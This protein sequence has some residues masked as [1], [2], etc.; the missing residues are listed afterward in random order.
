MKLGNKIE[1]TER[2]VLVKT[3]NEPRNTEYHD[4]NIVKFKAFGIYIGYR[5]LNLGYTNYTEDGPQFKRTGTIK[6][7]LVVLN[8]RKNPIYI[9]F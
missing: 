3:Y 5:Y 1:F 4:W 9:P 8:E 7:A 2:L 6:A